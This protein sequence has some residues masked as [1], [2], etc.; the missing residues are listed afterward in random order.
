[1]NAFIS[2]CQVNAFRET[3]L[4][5]KLFKDHVNVEWLTICSSTE[6][7]SLVFT[8][9]RNW[10]AKALGG[11][12][13]ANVTRK[14]LSDCVCSPTILQTLQLKFKWEVSEGTVEKCEICLRDVQSSQ[15][16]L[17]KNST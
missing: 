2:V 12:E 9:G 11:Q 5:E 15:N 17:L 13:S 6:G 14:S 3:S 7:T 16:Y 8:G 1:M 10:K 4:T